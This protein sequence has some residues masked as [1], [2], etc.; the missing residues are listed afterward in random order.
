MFQN[1]LFCRKESFWAKIF[2]DTKVI[3]ETKVH[4]YSFF[5]MEN[6]QGNIPHYVCR[7]DLIRL[8]DY[9]PGEN[10]MPQL[11]QFISC[12]KPCEMTGSLDA[13]VNDLSSLKY[14]QEANVEQMM[15]KV[16]AMDL[17]DVLRCPAETCQD[18]E[19]ASNTIDEVPVIALGPVLALKA[20]QEALRA[21]PGTSGTLR[22]PLS[23]IGNGHAVKLLHRGVYEGNM[24]LL[25]DETGS[26]WAL[27]VLVGWGMK[28]TKQRAL[29]Q[30][31]RVLSRPT[32][33]LTWDPHFARHRTYTCESDVLVPSFYY[34][35]LYASLVCNTETNLELLED[36]RNVEIITT[37]LNC[38]VY[39]N[40]Q[41]RLLLNR[42]GLNVPSII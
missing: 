25:Y 10:I 21:P 5:T 26:I 34:S 8:K 41:D 38:S 18:V 39:P 40:L 24:A 29:V 31:V 42:A 20:P 13:G 2:S 33:P 9:L 19:D 6:I 23:C 35:H 30:I 3:T 36:K 27:V 16:A 1:P 11:L 7:D 14:V 32:A 12:S 15:E 17:G 22:I 28:D 4:S 37:L